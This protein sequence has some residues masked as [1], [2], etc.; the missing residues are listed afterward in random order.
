MIHSKRYHDSAHNQRPQHAPL[1]QAMLHAL[2]HGERAEDDQ[3]QKQ[4]V[5]AEG[6]FDQVAGEELE[7]RLASQEPENA[8]A[9]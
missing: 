2:V 4:V 3:K 1:K 5:D 8:D 9:E 6:F 7:R